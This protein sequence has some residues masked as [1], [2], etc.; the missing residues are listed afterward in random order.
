MAVKSENTMAEG[1]QSLTQD[2]A[3]MKF[4]PDADL[5]FLVDLE[6]RIISYL[7]QGM[8]QTQQQ[9]SPNSNGP[10]PG[11]GGPGGMGGG[12]QMPM[13]AAAGQ[14]AYHQPPGPPM[15]PGLPPTDELA[16]L[17]SPS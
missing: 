1:L 3:T 10:M 14:Q 17:M 16:R 13:G 2:I 4:M 6:T 5:P 7:R 11:M 15:S 8:D 9:A 12:M